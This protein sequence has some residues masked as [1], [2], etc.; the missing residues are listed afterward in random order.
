MASRRGIVVQLAKYF[1]LR[2]YNLST[3]LSHFSLRNI[4]VAVITVVVVFYQS[5]K[6][7]VGGRDNFFIGLSKFINH[8][9]IKNLY[10]SMHRFSDFHPI[11]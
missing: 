8:S 1:V 6:V 2:Y 5:V 10:I 11:N 4:A 9:N 7:I 3:P